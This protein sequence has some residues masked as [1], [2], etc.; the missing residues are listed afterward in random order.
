[1]FGAVTRNCF[2][3]CGVGDLGLFA[4]EFST[5]PASLRLC[6]GRSEFRSRHKESLLT[7]TRDQ[8]GFN[9]STAVGCR[10]SGNGRKRTRSLQKLLHLQLRL[11]QPI[12]LQVLS[13]CIRLLVAKLLS[14]IS[15]A[16]FVL[17]WNGCLPIIAVSMTSTCGV[18]SK[19]HELGLDLLPIN[20]RSPD[21][22][23]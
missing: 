4:Q 15:C 6:D 20:R 5:T 2:S 1:M 13:K 19:S 17:T 3:D 10:S 9:E 14:A 8:S 21:D 18:T 16:D 22:R 12:D 11:D 23:R 7:G